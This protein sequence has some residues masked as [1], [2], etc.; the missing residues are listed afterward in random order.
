MSE[1][2]IYRPYR[3][4][5]VS[6]IVRGIRFAGVLLL[7]ALVGLQLLFSYEAL[8]AIGFAFAVPITI[9]FF[10]V[11]WRINRYKQTFGIF[12]KSRN[13]I[14]RHTEGERTLSVGSAVATI[15]RPVRSHIWT[16][17][18]S[19]AVNEVMGDQIIP[20]THALVIRDDRTGHQLDMTKGMTPRKMHQLCDMINNALKESRE[21][22]N[23]PEPNPTQRSERVR[24]LGG[25]NLMPMVREI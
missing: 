1:Q 25:R 18:T 24:F 15:E 9:F 11:V 3:G 13:L 16:P 19:E 10:F 2:V 7:L 6:P 5:L 17:E 23:Y 21:H 14:I 20:H 22:Y 4:E 8:G 12:I